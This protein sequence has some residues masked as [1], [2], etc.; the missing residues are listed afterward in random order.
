M[1]FVKVFLDYLKLTVIDAILSL[2]LNLVN[3]LMVR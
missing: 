2:N 3:S 1:A